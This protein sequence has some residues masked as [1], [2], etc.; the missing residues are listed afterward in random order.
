MKFIR[1]FAGKS[2]L[3]TIGWRV[4][5]IIR[6]VV[7]ILII[8]IIAM[9]ISCVYV[10]VCVCWWPEKQQQFPFAATIPN[11]SNTIREHL[12][13]C[14]FNMIGCCDYYFFTYGQEIITNIHTI[15]TICEH[16]TLKRSIGPFDLSVFVR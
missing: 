13:F 15:R 7:V 3:S 6:S 2:E 8:I 1:R 12:L 4:K 10:C 11:Y 16:L 14:N 5:G 9:N